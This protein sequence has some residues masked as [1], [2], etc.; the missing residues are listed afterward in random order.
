MGADL[1][2][3]VEY[4]II[5]TPIVFLDDSKGVVTEKQKI[6]LIEKY[7]KSPKFKKNITNATHITN[8]GDYIKDKLKFITKKIQYNKK[9]DVIEVIGIFSDDKSVKVP[10]K[11]HD[12]KESDILYHVKDGLHKESYAGEIIIGSSKGNKIYL[13]LHSKNISVDKV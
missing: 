3:N 6:E 4:K 5:I 1:S 10:M 11:L 13:G 12:T 7:V 9:N 2:L 8:M